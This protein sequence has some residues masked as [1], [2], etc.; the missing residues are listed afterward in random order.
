MLPLSNRSTAAAWVPTCPRSPTP[1]STAS[2]SRSQPVIAPHGWEA[3]TCR[4][5]FMKKCHLSQSRSSPGPGPKG[6]GNRHDSKSKI[7]LTLVLFVSQ[8]RWMWIDGEGFY[9]TNWYSQ[10]SSSSSPCIYLRSSCKSTYLAT[11]AKL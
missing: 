10:S 5:E 4:S 1:E 8:G 7:F 6:S 9:Y 2:S 3:S 11:L